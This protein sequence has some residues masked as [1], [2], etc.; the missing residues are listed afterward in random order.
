MGDHWWN[1]GL[2]NGLGIG[3]LV[4]GIGLGIGTCSKYV[5][6]GNSVSIAQYDA[7]R[8]KYEAQA[9]EHKLEQLRL[10][11]ENRGDQK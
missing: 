8:A 3:A 6:S 5:P 10:Q 11:C 4:L 7:E 1:S 9:E 2:G